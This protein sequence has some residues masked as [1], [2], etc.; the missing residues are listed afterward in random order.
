MP[1]HLDYCHSS[2]SYSKCEVDAHVFGNVGIP[3]F[4]RVPLG[5]VLQPDTAA[6]MRGLVDLASQK[7][8]WGDGGTYQFALFE[9]LGG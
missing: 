6:C 5:P 7:V 2:G 4:V 1:T 3:T 9:Q 8:V